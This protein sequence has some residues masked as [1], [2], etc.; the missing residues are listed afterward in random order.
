LVTPVKA[1]VTNRL[2]DTILAIEAELGVQPSSTFSTV[3]AR[4]DS[5]SNILSE[6]GVN[7]SG[8][9]DTVAERLDDIELNILQLQNADRIIIPLAINASVQSNT[10]YTVIGGD[11]FNPADYLEAGRQIIFV[12]RISTIDTSVSADIRLFNVT[13]NTSVSSTEF[14]TLSDVTVRNEAILSVPTDLP[15]EEKTYEV[16]LKQGTLSANPVFCIKA[17]LHIILS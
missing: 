5:I 1:E 17:E 6:L 9:F 11:E 4:I 10:A 8:T 13:D 2:R 14:S 3:R 12:A 16:Q 15:N 7:S